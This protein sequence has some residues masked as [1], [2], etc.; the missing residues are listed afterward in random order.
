VISSAANR[1]AIWPKKPRRVGAVDVGLHGGNPNALPPG[2]ELLC[3]GG[4]E[5]VRG[6]EQDVFVLCDQDTGQ[7]AHGGGLAH[8][9]DADHHHDGGPVSVPVDP[10]AP[11][12]GRVHDLDELFAEQGL[13]VLGV[14]RAEDLHA[15][16][17]CVHELHGGFSAKISQEQGFL[18]LVPDVLIDLVAGEQRQQALAQDVVGL[19]QALPEA[20][21][22]AGHGQR[23]LHRDGLES[24]RVIRDLG[25]QPSKVG[26][27]RRLPVNG[28][29]RRGGAVLKE[30]RAAG[31]GLHGVVGVPGAGL[32]RAGFPGLH[33]DRDQP[34]DDY[35]GSKNGQKNG[36]NVIH[37]PSFSQAAGAPGVQPRRPLP[38]AG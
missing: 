12:H 30:G 23:G 14:A 1:L 16:A 20:G 28:R 26:G 5:S 37:T 10:Q 4:T 31:T 29:R 25:F 32:L 17:Q 15:F 27:V 11:V 7:L 2:G 38:A 33:E 6:T 21:E 35:Q 8:A 19:D 3:G 9:V 18:H 36:D 24:G 22:P 13:H 34:A